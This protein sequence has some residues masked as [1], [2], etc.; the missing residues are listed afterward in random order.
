MTHPLDP[1]TSSSNLPFPKTPD[2]PLNF[3]P[4]P[5]P[6]SVSPNTPSANSDASPANSDGPLANF[7]AFPAATDTYPGSPKPQEPPPLFLIFTTHHQLNTLVPPTHSRVSRQP[8]GDPC[9]QMIPSTYQRSPTLDCNQH[10]PTP[11]S[12]TKPHRRS[13]HTLKFSGNRQIIS[14]PTLTLSAKSVPSHKV[15]P[16]PKTAR[17]TPLTPSEPLDTALDPGNTTPGPPLRLRHLIKGT[18]GASPTTMPWDR[19]IGAPRSKPHT[20]YPLWSTQKQA[21]CEVISQSTLKVADAFPKKVASTW[22]RLLGSPTPVPPHD[23]L[24]CRPP[25]NHEQPSSPIQAQLQEP[26]PLLHDNSAALQKTSL[27]S[28]PSDLRHNPTRK[29]RPNPKPRIS[30]GPLVLVLGTADRQNAPQT[31]SSARTSPKANTTNKPPPSDPCV[32]SGT[33]HFFPD[34]GTTNPQEGT[35][36]G[37]SPK[38]SPLR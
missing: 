11:S 18:Y 31:P 25:S 20:K 32:D 8:Q 17:P 27:W 34:E 5:A 16:D 3:R 7:D 23:Q 2:A 30:S 1:R 12:S 24:P 35:T 22:P 37:M 15:D 14:H 38:A 26:P 9:S 33:A 19:I 4:C 13:Q 10:P 36:L 6:I 21:T 29:L 28:S